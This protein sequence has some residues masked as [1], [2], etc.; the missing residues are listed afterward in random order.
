MN[1]QNKIHIITEI[2]DN[3]LKE[4]LND[5]YNKIIFTNDTDDFENLESSIIK[6]I[7]DIE[8][9]DNI[10]LKTF[11]E[12]MENHHK[13]ELWFSALIGFFHQHGIGK[14]EK[15]R[16]KALELYLHSIENDNLNDDNN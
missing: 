14:N 12:F 4:F 11:V 13:S 1:V 3:F 8:N 16:N 7:N 6:W 2:S 15:N 9:V 10:N 5:I